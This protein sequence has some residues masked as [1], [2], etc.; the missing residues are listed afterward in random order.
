MIPVAADREFTVSYSLPGYLPQV[1]PVRPRMPE[2]VQLDVEAGGALPSVDL[3]PNPV[4]AQLQPAATP[5]DDQKGPRTG[6]AGGE[7]Q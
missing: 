1:I 2:L 5:A 7:K 6:A 3:T 4:Y